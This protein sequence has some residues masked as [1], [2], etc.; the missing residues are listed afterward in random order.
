[1]SESTATTRDAANVLEPAARLSTLNRLLPVWIGAAML[2]GIVLGRAFPDLNDQLE[3]VKIDTV[4]LPIAV[5]LFA[6]AEAH[7]VAGDHKRLVDA[8]AAGEIEAIDAEDL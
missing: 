1:M 3:K 4:S 8:I 5:G 7:F 2:A 6:V